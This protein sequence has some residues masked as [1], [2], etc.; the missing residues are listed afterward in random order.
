MA[1]E[2]QSSFE[3]REIRYSIAAHQ[4]K[5]GGLFVNESTI[6]SNEY[7]STI[8][9]MFIDEEHI[10]EDNALEKQGVLQA[11]VI[12]SPKALH[13]LKNML[14]ELTSHMNDADRG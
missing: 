3:V 6:T 9:F 12:M 13:D 4:S 5:R 7:G 2:G 14:V 10:T 11:R 8:D 1:T